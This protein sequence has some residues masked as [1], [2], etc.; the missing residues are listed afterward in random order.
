MDDEPDEDEATGPPDTV[1]VGSEDLGQKEDDDT[2]VETENKDSILDLE[3]S[4]LEDE[5]TEDHSLVPLELEDNTDKADLPPEESKDLTGS[6][7]PEEDDMD[8][9]QE[10]EILEEASPEETSALKR[11]YKRMKSGFKRR[12]QSNRKDKEEQEEMDDEPDEDEATGPPDTVSVGSEDLGQKEEDDTLVETENKYS[13]LDLEPLKLEDG[14]SPVPFQ[15][16]EETEDHSLV[17]LE[18]EDKTNKPEEDEIDTMET[19]DLPQESEILEEA[20]PEETSALKRV[21]KKVKSEFKRRFRSNRKEKEE[22]EEMDDEPDEDEAIDTCPPDTECH[23]DESTPQFSLDLGQTT[24]VLPSKMDLQNLKKSLNYIMDVYSQGLTQEQRNTING[25]IKAD[26]GG[27]IMVELRNV[28][29]LTI[30]VMKECI[31]PSSNPL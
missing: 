13:I 1:S 10:S 17:P 30:E 14:L 27:M 8:L 16:D 12:F 6:T 3:P 24:G 11:V 31:H 29:D 23:F 19:A 7:K 20:S 22:Q 26:L 9:P 25:H 21:Y 28:K 4:K 5:D 2:L 18:L 15:E